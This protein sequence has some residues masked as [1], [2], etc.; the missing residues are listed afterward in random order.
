MQAIFFV[1]R[2]RH[3]TKKKSSKE[4]RKLKLAKAQQAKKRRKSQGKSTIWIL[5]Q[6][7]L[8][9]S[10]V[11]KVDM[12]LYPEARHETLNETNREDVYQDVLSWLASLKSEV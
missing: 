6:K 12:L 9:E 7:I 5:L 4:P 10:G 2:M 1:E 3:A 11:R 8:Q